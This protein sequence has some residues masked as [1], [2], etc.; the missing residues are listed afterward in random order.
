MEAIRVEQVM[1]QDGQLVL[2]DL[3]YKRGQV[4]EVIVVPW[5]STMRSQLTV[6]QLRRSGLIGM[7]KER[8]DIVDSSKY[9]RRL[10]EQAQQRRR[11]T[12]DLVG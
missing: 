7:W 10:R 8:A 12:H 5:P 6:G 3:P 11:D 1:I 2:R 9:A 4:L